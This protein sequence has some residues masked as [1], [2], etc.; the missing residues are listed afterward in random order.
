M[1]AT[2]TLIV[3]VVAAAA[4][5]FVGKKLA[6]ETFTGIDEA[7]KAVGGAIGKSIYE[8]FHPTPAD[9]LLTF[10]FTFPDGSRGSVNG[11][12]LAPDGSFTYW[13]DGTRWRLAKGSDGVNYAVPR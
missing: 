11:E 9:A 8:W 6:S 10:M 13:R 2:D 7:R 12:V 3:A 1:K 4:V 5:Y